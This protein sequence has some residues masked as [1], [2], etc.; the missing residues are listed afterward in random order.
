MAVLTFFLFFDTFLV[1]T[2]CSI[3]FFVLIDRSK[4]KKF[5]NIFCPAS[6]LAVQKILKSPED[7]SSGPANARLQFGK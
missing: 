2:K 3:N 5:F 4:E 1:S 7:F 6:K